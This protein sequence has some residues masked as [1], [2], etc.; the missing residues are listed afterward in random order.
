LVAPAKHG[1]RI[2]VEIASEEANVFRRA[3]LSPPS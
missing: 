1:C 3:V 2:E